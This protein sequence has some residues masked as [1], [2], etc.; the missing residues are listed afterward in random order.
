MQLHFSMPALARFMGLQRRLRN[1]KLRVSDSFKSNPH[2]TLARACRSP[3]GLADRGAAHRHGRYRIRRRAGSGAAGRSGRRR[4]VDVHSVLGY[5]VFLESPRRPRSATLWGRRRGEGDAVAE[6]ARWSAAV[7]L[8]AAGIGAGLIAVGWPSI[9]G[10]VR[11]MGAEGRV[12]ALAVEYTRIRLFGAPAVLITFAAFGALRGIQ[13]MRA[14]L[15]IA[16]AVNALNI[17][18]DYFLIFRLRPAERDG[19]R[20]GRRWQAR[21]ASGSA[22]SGRRALHGARSAGRRRWIGRACRGSSP[23]AGTFFFAP[24]C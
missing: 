9:P 1:G 23:T 4:A 21:S 22:L 16:G 15:W 17:V 6:A 7:V 20:A 2:G 12:A 5:S 14:P 18:L 24:R 19:R 11:A 10:C 13:Q 8:L 3:I